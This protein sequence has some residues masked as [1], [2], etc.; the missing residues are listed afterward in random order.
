MFKNLSELTKATI[1]QKIA[2]NALMVCG[3]VNWFE[4]GEEG[5]IIANWED[6]DYGSP[7]DYIISKKGEIE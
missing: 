5:N 3:C 7:R 6:G 1:E 2:L 4:Y